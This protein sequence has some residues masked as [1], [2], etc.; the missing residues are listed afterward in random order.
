M[1][2]R[3][4]KIVF[5]HHPD[6]PFI[7]NLGFFI[8]RF[9]VGL[10]LCTVFEKLFPRNGIWG[11]QDWFIQDVADMG[12]PFPLFFAW[13]AVLSEFFGGILLML[14]FLTRPAALLNIGVTFIAT[15]IYHNGDIASSGLTS[16]FFMIMCI[17][18]AFFGSGKF[19][20]DYY[21]NLKTKNNND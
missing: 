15:F 11:P 6:A 1:V 7:Y 19:G 10:A 21:I 2:Q 9:F 13:L 12:F 3:L 17:C 18:I 8:L 14:G 16:F 5:F 20:L 4:R